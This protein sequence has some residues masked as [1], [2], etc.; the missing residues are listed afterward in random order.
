MDKQTTK[1]IFTPNCKEVEDLAVE[2][3]EF[4]D[5]YSTLR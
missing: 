1:D 5:K 3:D 4:I 2:L